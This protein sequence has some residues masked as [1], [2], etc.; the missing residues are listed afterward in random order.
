MVDSKLNNFI[1]KV[2]RR[3]ASHD[4]DDDKQ[5]Q[6]PT[7]HKKQRT[8]RVQHA[9][10]VAQTMEVLYKATNDLGSCFK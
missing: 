6:L 5:A 2:P 1:Y 8:K 7:L 3:F 10:S 4:K 9:P